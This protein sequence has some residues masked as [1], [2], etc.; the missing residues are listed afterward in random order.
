MDADYFLI[1]IKSFKGFK[2]NWLE[3]KYIRPI[4]INENAVLYRIS[5][6][7]EKGQGS[8]LPMLWIITSLTGGLPLKTLPVLRKL[9]YFWRKL[10]THLGT[11]IYEKLPNYQW[12]FCVCFHRKS[13]KF[14]FIKIRLVVVNLRSRNEALFSFRRS[15]GLA[16]FGTKLSFF[17]GQAFVRRFSKETNII[18]LA[19]PNRWQA[20]TLR[21]CGACFGAKCATRSWS[22]W[23]HVTR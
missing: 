18:R 16:C 9:P 8:N 19:A 13:L 21:L 6:E 17:H 12:L 7:N 22:V 1:N 2:Q 5:D 20:F 23:R 3:W 15:L 11:N 10:R 4:F 14:L